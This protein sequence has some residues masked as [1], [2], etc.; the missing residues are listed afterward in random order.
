MTP[1]EEQEDFRL[2]PYW[3]TIR[4]ESAVIIELRHVDS[5]ASRNIVAVAEINALDPT[6]WQLTR[7]EMLDRK[8]DRG[9]HSTPWVG[10]WAAVVLTAHTAGVATLA[11]AVDLPTL[12]KI[13]T[14]GL[15]P[16]TGG[17]CDM[18]QYR[19]RL[20]RAHPHAHRLHFR[21]RGLEGLIHPPKTWALPIGKASS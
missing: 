12:A 14:A 10:L 21:G 19:D 2:P 13:Q 17:A 20:Y 1:E 7:F 15:S 16:F 3:L 11:E 18:E 6:L 5:S 8:F 4:N 9:P